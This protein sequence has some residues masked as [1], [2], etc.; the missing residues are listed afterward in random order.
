MVTTQDTAWMGTDLE[1][2]E[3]MYKFGLRVVQLTYNMHN[4]VGSGCTERND[5]G[6]SK[7]GVNF[8]KKMN[9]LGIIVDTGHTGRQST[10]EACEIQMRQ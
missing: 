10:L 5:T 6:I 2:L 9:D 8:I 4:H 3:M 1:N 7:F